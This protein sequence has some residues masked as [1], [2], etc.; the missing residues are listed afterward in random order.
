MEMKYTIRG[1]KNIQY[2]DNQD[3]ILSTVTRIQNII[4]Q[5]VKSKA[6]SGAFGLSLY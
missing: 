2:Y 5:K 4:L 3:A 6:Q 1:K